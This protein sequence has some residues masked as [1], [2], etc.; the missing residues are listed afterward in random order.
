MVSRLE[1]ADDLAIS[2]LEYL[3]DLPVSRSNGSF[4]QLNF[5]LDDLIISRPDLFVK[6]K[7][8]DDLPI[9]RLGVTG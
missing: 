8:L 7:N 6:K 5:D 3:D 4:L 9:S 2:R 1:V